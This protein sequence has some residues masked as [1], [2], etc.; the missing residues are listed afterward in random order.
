MGKDIIVVTSGFLQSGVHRV[1][2]ELVEEW[3]KQGHRVSFIS[4]KG[5]VL[6]DAS[7]TE[8]QKQAQQSK[9]KGSLI[10]R[11]KGLR[12]FL[13]A[14]KDATIVAL[15]LP[16][17]CFAAILSLFIPNKVVISERNDP[18]QYPAE[19]WY[20]ALRNF[21][22]RLPDVCVFQTNEAKAYFSPKVQK[23][24]V[25]IPNPINPELPDIVSGQRKKNV[26]A[27]GRLKPQKN[28]HMLIRAF[29]LF[30]KDFPDYVLDIYGEGYLQSELE[31]LAAEC[32][33]ADKVF[34]HG[35]STQVFPLLAEA[36]MFVSSSDYEGI[37][38]AMLEALAIGTPTVCTDCPVGGA[39][40]MIQDGENG[41]LVPVGDAQALYR[42][43]SRVAAD[44]AFAARLSENGRKI[45][46]LYPVHVI[47]E[48]WIQVM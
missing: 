10:R 6:S 38:N 2:S 43:M 29:A 48:K 27:L 34:I 17:D 26:I 37:S 33:V 44:E 18:R 23:K 9:P 7:W 31:A 22:F 13:K 46:E 45:R 15:S 21:C 24:G 5:R 41:L 3:E 16:A 25:V 35:F 19:K 28:F 11:I 14:H 12:R 47:A 8:E 42:A 30:S 20:R 39:R 1:E 40:E 36:G 4:Y 32:Q